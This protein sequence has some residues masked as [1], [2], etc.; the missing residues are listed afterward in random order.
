M[1]FTAGE[2]DSTGKAPPQQPSQAAAPPKSV[3]AE[4]LLPSSS[5]KEKE[6][7]KVAEEKPRSSRFARMFAAEAAAASQASDRASPAGGSAA[8]SPSPIPSGTGHVP[9]SSSSNN[10][11]AALL[12]GAARS[13]APQV[14]QG[15][16][17]PAPAATQ[18]DNQSMARLM[19]MLHMSSAAPP[20]AP[21]I[22]TMDGKLPEN[23][24]TS[25]SGAANGQNRSSSSSRVASQPS[26]SKG[27]APVDIPLHDSR[28][29]LY[30]PDFHGVANS[31]AQ[32]VPPRHQGQPSSAQHL[33]PQQ[34]RDTLPSP[35][36][37]PQSRL[38]NRTS[39]YNLNTSSDG[40]SP[41][42]NARRQEPLH[43][44]VP[45]DQG[46]VNLL[47]LL[48]GQMSPPAGAL[49]PHLQNFPSPSQ[50]QQQQ[51]H[52]HS[53]GQPMQSPPSNGPFTP[54]GG[55]MPDHQHSQMA[56]FLQA[57]AGGAGRPLPPPGVPGAGNMQ[58]GRPVG[59]G[60]FLPSQGPYPPHQGP[61][62]PPLQQHQQPQHAGHMRTPSGHMNAASLLQQQ[63]R[64]PHNPQQQ[65]QPF[66][67]MRNDGSTSQPLPPPQAFAQQNAL[68]QLLAQGG[69]PGQQFAGMRPP[70]NGTL[71]YQ[72]QQQHPPPPMH[73]QQ[74]SPMHMHHS[75]PP[76][77]QQN[78]IDLMALLT[79]GS[80]VGGFAGR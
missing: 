68:A 42:Q 21:S 61:F 17:S 59:Q 38:A 48:G 24:M 44:P 28:N 26:R 29:G 7:N 15:N 72:Q 6:L 10:L 3:F 9:H 25:E 54:M 45:P 22:A 13:P 16:S 2:G 53:R 60:P 20:S 46:S 11:L 39:A 49:P 51:Q 4:F 55:S 75:S 79:G 62:P 31:Q 73:M 77:N 43:A 33:S 50:H 52:L 80:N 27:Q 35:H 63:Q 5:S 8:A 65:Q 1:A 69:H 34:S 37:L 76:P 58:F 56:A 64:L 78:Q 14:N 66:N 36:A 57:Q 70:S 18:T 12:P 67:P 30:S 40:P 19:E 47:Q 32:Q 23:A 71:S 74:T 41:S